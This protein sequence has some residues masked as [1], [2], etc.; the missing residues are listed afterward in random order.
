MDAG[1]AF[2]ARFSHEN[3]NVVWLSPDCARNIESPPTAG[4]V[5][6]LLVFLLAICLTAEILAR[7][8]AAWI[9]HEQSVALSFVSA[10]AFL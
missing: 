8:I 9:G 1:E 2:M 7:V 5:A 4:G 10:S 3:G 6:A